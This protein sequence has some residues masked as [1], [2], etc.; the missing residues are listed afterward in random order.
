MTA[1]LAACPLH[2]HAKSRR[3]KT[4]T[5]VFQSEA[6]A[7]IKMTTCLS[8]KYW[9][10]TTVTYAGTTV[11]YDFHPGV[12]RETQKSDDGARSSSRRRRKVTGSSARRRPLWQV[13]DPEAPAL[14]GKAHADASQL[15]GG[16][17]RRN[18]R[19]H[20]DHEVG[21]R[22][23]E[24]AWLRSWHW[25]RHRR[26]RHRAGVQL[27]HGHRLFAEATLPLSFRFGQAERRVFPFSL[28]V[29]PALPPL[30]LGLA[31]G[32]AAVSLAVFVVRLQVEQI[33]ADAAWVGGHT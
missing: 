31:A 7:K 32:F 11:T 15:K 24:K 13:H 6:K 26:R 20:A 33:A 25:P 22:K 5:Y 14:L 30:A 2:Y 17:A 9:K 12:R 16:H 4:V 8:A 3:H 21:D 19:D 10:I 23:V 18:V 28:I 27:A 29:P 1:D